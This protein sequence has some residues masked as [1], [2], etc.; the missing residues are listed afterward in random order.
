MSIQARLLNQVLHL[1]KG[2]WRDITTIDSQLIA[3]R[4]KQLYRWLPNIPKHIAV[5]S[6]FV[7]QVPVQVLSAAGSKPNIILLYFHGGGF[8]AGLPETSHRDYLWRVAEE[9]GCCLWA[10]GYR[11]LPDNPFPAAL[12][13]A[14]QVYRHLLE[15]HPSCNVCVA[16]DSAG[17]GLALSLVLKIKD[18]GMTLP[19]AV[20]AFSPWSDLT[21]SGE[22]LVGNRQSEVMIP[23][24]LLALLAGE[25][26]GKNLLTDPYISPL[27]GDFNGFPP[28]MMMV[29]DAEVLLDDSLRVADSMREADVTLDFFLGQ[30]LP[31]AWPVFAR[32]LPEGKTALSRFA[33]FVE[34]RC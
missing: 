27:F 29:S 26:A 25:Y 31:H 18:E 14:Y 20:A 15:E 22:S 33:E 11:K 3:R 17:G 28:S 4:E 2:F 16:G 32:F 12:D 1:N 13:D 9:T 23:D 30:G 24:H 7:E 8:I 10:V 34:K 5:K 21:C 6:T 19:A